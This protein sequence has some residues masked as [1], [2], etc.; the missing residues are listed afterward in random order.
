MSFDDNEQADIEIFSV[1][2]LERILRTTPDRVELII[3]TKSKSDVW[4]TFRLIRVDGM[5]V[6]NLCACLRCKAMFTTS[7]N[8]GTSHL[9]QHPK[10]CTLCP[11][12]TFTQLCLE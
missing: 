5:L 10:S 11:S 2:E 3:N 12:K 9:L 4:E 6:P 8:A 7:R 1:P